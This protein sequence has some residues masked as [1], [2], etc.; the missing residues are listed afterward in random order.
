MKK[1]SAQHSSST[2]AFPTAICHCFKAAQRQAQHRTTQAAQSQS[3]F[4]I[5][6]KA[7]YLQQ[8]Q[9]EA[10]AVQAQAHHAACP[11]TPSG[12]ATATTWSRPTQATCLAPLSPLTAP[13]APSG[14]S[15]TTACDHTSPAAM[16]ANPSQKGIATLSRLRPR[17]PPR[18][19]RSGPV[20]PPLSHSSRPPSPYKLESAVVANFIKPNFFL[21]G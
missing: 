18:V 14:A 10:A 9:L 16:K 1:N 5:S 13:R 2:Q 20:P 3:P 19:A 17:S 7:L 15:I 21:W 8:R 12:A 6:L 4:A 11:P